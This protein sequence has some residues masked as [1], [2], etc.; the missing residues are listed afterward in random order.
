MYFINDDNII[1]RLPAIDEHFAIT[2]Q[3][4]NEHT[5]LFNLKMNYTKKKYSG[6]VLIEDCVLKTKT[7]KINDL[8]FGKVYLQKD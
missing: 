2:T 1:T 7:K 8:I 3:I 6:G 5:Y 4:V